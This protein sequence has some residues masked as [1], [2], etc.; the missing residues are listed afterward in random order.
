MRGRAIAL[1]CGALL[2]AGC[3]TTGSGQTMLVD[4]GQAAVSREFRL[5]QSDVATSVGRFLVAS[6]QAAGDPPPG[7]ATFTTQR[8][9]WQ[10]LIESYAERA[11]VD[12]T[13]S[14]VEDQMAQLEA[15]S[16]G[17]AG[18]AQRALQSGIP[19]EELEATLRADLLAN[20]IAVSLAPDEEIAA[21]A[22]AFEAA[23]T[24]YSEEIGVA[25]APRYGT[26]DDERLG[27]VPGSPLSESAEPQAAS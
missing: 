25:V 7:L 26:W 5:S 10:L 12:V 23:V 16:G 2:L 8:L 6:G 1:T 13:R 18:L 22:A 27:I 14:E 19:P 17:S 3:S 24:A 15:D 9:T 20:A 11:G 21:Q 4:S